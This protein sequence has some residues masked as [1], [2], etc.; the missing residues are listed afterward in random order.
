MTR[1]LN[2][3]RKSVL[4]IILSLVFILAGCSTVT[5]SSSNAAEN[6]SAESG[7][8]KIVKVAHTQ[9]FVPYDY[10]NEAGE[11]DGFEV[12]VLKAVD[13]KLLD[14]TFEFVPTSDD[15][16]LIGVESGKYDVGTKGAWYTEER[17]EKFIYPEEPVAASVIGLTFRTEDADEITDMSSFATYSGNLVPIA[18]QNAQYAIVEAYND[19]NPENTVKLVPAESF[20]LADA[21][22]WLLEGRYDAYFNIQL[23]YENNVV[24]EDA[25]YHDLKDQLSFV[26]YQ[27][28]PTWPLFNKEN[29]AFA[30]AYDEAV[31]ALKEDGTITELSEKYFG[32]DIFQYVSE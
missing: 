28:I 30:D 11:S 14:Y 18:P 29:Q 4:G 20:E 22:T 9:T 7:S 12:A 3:K 10:V 32:E 23:S 13:E 25:P 27:A 2:I 16:L 15:D 21:Y 19:A 26:P 8:P 17:A 1:S 5:P 24:A 6:A 31:K